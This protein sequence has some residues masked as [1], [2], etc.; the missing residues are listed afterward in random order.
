MIDSKK[1]F[2]K[3]KN[4]SLLL[5]EDYEPLRNEL[6]EIL[7]DYFS[8]VECASNGQEALT[9]YENYFQRH[10]V[11]FDLVVSD[12]QMPIMNGIELSKTLKQINEDQIIIIL[13]AHTDSDY[14]LKLINLGIAQ[15]IPKPI[16]DEQLLEVL[17]NVTKQQKNKE[18]KSDHLFI[19]H[20]SENYVW[21]MQKYVLMK[22]NIVINLTCSMMLLLKILID[23][24]DQ[25][26]T[27]NEIVQYFYMNGIDINEENIRNLVYKLRK[28]LP[29]KMINSLYG[30]GYK[31]IPVINVKD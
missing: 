19:L 15:F 16:E 11:H 2:I 6:S 28:K 18:K 10:K 9:S 25:I 5:V 1:L 30:M 29:P 7:K 26:N 24:H 21:D 20:S 13:S 8:V 12:I 4:L 27:N 31:L 23:R 22:N 3:T 14:L 17:D